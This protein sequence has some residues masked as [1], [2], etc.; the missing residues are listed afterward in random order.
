MPGRVQ[1]K[2]TLDDGARWNRRQQIVRRAGI[3]SRMSGQHNWLP[4]IRGMVL[5]KTQR[6]LNPAGTSERRLSLNGGRNPTWRQDG[7]AVVVAVAPSA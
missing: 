4:A 7:Q 6:A 3:G 2:G 5:D 1:G